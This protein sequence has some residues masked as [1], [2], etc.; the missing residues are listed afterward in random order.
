[1]ILLSGYG[2]SFMKTKI[3]SSHVAG[4]KVYA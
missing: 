1:M 2:I 3:A 4:S